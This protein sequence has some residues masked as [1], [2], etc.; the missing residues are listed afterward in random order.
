MKKE[1]KQKAEPIKTKSS[2]VFKIVL[3]A[4]VLISFAFMWFAGYVLAEKK[5]EKPQK[6]SVTV[7]MQ[8]QEEKAP[9][10]EVVKTIETATPS[11]EQIIVEDL[12]ETKDSVQETVAVAQEEVK[13]Q[14]AYIAIVIDDMGI[15]P[16]HTPEILSIQAPI[17]SSFL[18][19]GQNLHEYAK[20]ALDAGHE[21]LMH[22][23][24]EPKVEADIAPDTLKISM[25][26]DELSTAFSYM[27]A[28][29]EGLPIKGTNNHMGSL[30]TESAPKLDVIMKILKSKNLFFLD[31]KTTEYSQAEVVAKM[32]D[33]PY[34]AR[35]IFLD[36]E[37]DY[38]KIMAQF[39]I[40]EAVAE[41]TGF[42]VAIGHPKS[43]TYL[44]L[45]DWVETLKDK[46]VKLIHLSDMINL[47]NQK[48]NE[49]AKKTLD[50]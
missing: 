10:V 32:E 9:V 4:V 1:N 41:K 19:Y 16:K 2:F 3:A 18:T 24:M 23:P 39:R 28:K 13:P 12:V 22:T 33:V 31:S 15:S 26:D 45:R 29:F 42:A 30:F 6:T 49:Q 7:V 44:A 8:S 14:K 20:A 50:E 38:E 36:N 46:N 35:D 17:T 47:K 5:V 40:T 34:I 43:Q 11:K 27:L 37:N 25:T 48:N 21:L